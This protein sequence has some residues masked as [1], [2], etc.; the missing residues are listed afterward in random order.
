LTEHR[1]VWIVFAPL[2]F[3]RDPDAS[4]HLADFKQA[5]QGSFVLVERSRFQGITLLRYE[6]KER[7]GAT[8]EKIG[9]AP[10]RIKA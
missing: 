7:V 1:G 9:R 6:R 10:G 4:P 3:E 5:M 2:N 8:R